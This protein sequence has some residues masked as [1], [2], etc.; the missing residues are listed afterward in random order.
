MS[1]IKLNEEEIL[2]LKQVTLNKI[3][4]LPIPI[5]EIPE[6]V[7]DSWNEVFEISN[8]SK[9]FSI[10]TN[11]FPKPQMMGFFLEILIGKKF[12]QKSKDWLFDPTGYSKDLTNT[13]NEELSIEIKTSSNKSH[14]YGNRSYANPGATSKKS[15]NSFY[16][17]INFE[18]FDKNN[19][20]KRPNITLIRFGYLEHSDWVG[21][22]AASGQQA[23]LTSLSEK[24]KLLQIWPELD[25][26]LK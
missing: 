14:I 21:Q 16:L 19:L 10:G 3:K 2:K 8:P 22:A 1:R 24:G 5:T 25:P 20:A 7:I 6:I 13:K 17:A 11:V 12:E 26:I 4:E 23:H 18:K 9:S 15:K